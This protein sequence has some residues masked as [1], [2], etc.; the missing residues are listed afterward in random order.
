[1]TT[2]NFNID[3]ENIKEPVDVYREALKKQLGICGTSKEEFE[4][5]AEKIR[6]EKEAAFERLLNVYGVSFL[7]AIEGKIL[8]QFAELKQRYI[9]NHDPEEHVYCLDCR[10]FSATE[11]D[12]HC[13]YSGECYFWN[14]EDSAP[15]KDR[16][17]YVP[18]E[19]EKENEK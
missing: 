8:D 2:K 16:W 9:G 10:Y 1:M 6:K 3:Q 13:P 4:E 5:Y 19:E 18:R 7:E 15:R 14:P 12:L 11:D 17:H